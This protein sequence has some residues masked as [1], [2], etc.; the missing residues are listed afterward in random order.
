MI[1]FSDCVTPQK[2]TMSERCWLFTLE[3]TVQS[4]GNRNFTYRRFHPKVKTC[5][6]QL[7][8]IKAKNEK[9][10]GTLFSAIYFSQCLP[11]DGGI[12]DLLF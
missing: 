8:S 5:Q 12:D 6:K 11:L 10:K 4:L 9:N 7:L 2:C 3:M 1:F